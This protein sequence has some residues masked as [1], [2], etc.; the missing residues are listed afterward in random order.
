VG[1]RLSGCLGPDQAIPGWVHEPSCH[2][3]VST[4]AHPGFE[5][6]CGKPS[7]GLRGILDAFQNFEAQP[8]S[9]SQ[10]REDAPHEPGRGEVEE[11]EKQADHDKSAAMVHEEQ[12]E[13]LASGLLAG[14]SR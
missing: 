3:N 4:E 9:H 12:P 8:Q 5:A 1:G 10:N 11:K 2:A 14:G 6:F 13:L 7:G